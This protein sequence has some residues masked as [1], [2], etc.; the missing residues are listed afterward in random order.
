MTRMLKIT[1]VVLVSRLLGA[2]GPAQAADPLA[3]LRTAHPRLVALDSDIERVRGLIKSDPVARKMYGQL[4]EDARED[5]RAARG[6]QRSQVQTLALLYRLS[7]DRQ[8]AN[9]AVKELR[10]AAARPDWN[11][12]HFLDTAHMTLTFAI[13]YDWLYPALNPPDR[14]LI[15][16]AIVEKGLK[17]ALP[18]YEGQRPYPDSRMW[19][20]MNH[21]WN[22]QCNAGMV[23][24][25]LAIADEVPDLSR[26]VLERALE[27]VPRALASFAPDGGWA[28]GP[29]Y[30]HSTA[31]HAVLLITA[32]QSAL[33]SDFGLSDIEG[34][35]R[36]GHFGVYFAS[37]TGK[38]FNYAD[39]D[40]RLGGAPEMFWLAQRFSQPVYAWHQRSLLEGRRP[41]PLDLIWYQ[42]S[43]T[44]PV[45]AGWSPHACFEGAG[46][47]FLRSSW[48]DPNAIFVGIKGGNNAS[49][50]S[51]L[52]LGSFVLD[53]GG[54][55]WASDLG[56]EGYSVPGYFDL[57]RGGRWTVYR[58][59]TGAHNTV[60]LDG[61]SQEPDSRAPII[62]CGVG[63]DPPYVVIDLARGYPGKVQHF[64]RSLGLIQKTAVLIED[65]VEAR[66]PVNALWGMITDAAVTLRGRATDLVKA[67]WTLSAEILS[68]SNATFALA[69]TTPPKPQAQNDGTRK[70]IVR[71]PAKV[72]SLDLKVLLV[73][74]RTGQP[75]PEVTTSHS[76]PPRSR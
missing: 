48:D 12:S 71:L 7:G 75:K 27:S 14:D 49:N 5:L 52:D 4:A 15:R 54:L 40:E 42:A 60:L 25:A 45:K 73:P 6:G 46:V 30:W 22:V 32:L 74:H 61:Q 10:A 67:D 58:A 39:A 28:E 37:P 53:A 11:P 51:H 34:F 1:L 29:G 64:Q 56:G 18:I 24:G 19:A 23:L 35:S 43:T 31:S 62:D 17:E 41:S 72:S 21:N 9:R 2:L 36:T 57:Q 20:T 66:W 76:S 33:G 70:L 65:T 47:A 44:S 59:S 55:R 26:R 8:Y 16:T 13:A 50:H 69:A 3:T 63:A 38:S 68:P